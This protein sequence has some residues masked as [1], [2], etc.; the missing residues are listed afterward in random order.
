MMVGLGDVYAA[1]EVISDKLVR[2][3]L[4]HNEALSARLGQPIYLKLEN[5]QK[6]GSFKPRGVLTKIAALSDEEKRRGLVTISAGNHA[7]A[8]GYAARASGTRCTVVMPTT[9]PATKIANTRGYGA[10]VILHPDRVTL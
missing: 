1:R 8:L 3:P 10:E 6:T 2:T 4:L 9:A 5:L 7:Q